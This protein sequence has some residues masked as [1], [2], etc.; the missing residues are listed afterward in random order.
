MVLLG[1][2]ARTM[3]DLAQAALD[4]LDAINHPRALRILAEIGVPSS[5]G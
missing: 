1:R 5:N 2:I 3:P 4:A